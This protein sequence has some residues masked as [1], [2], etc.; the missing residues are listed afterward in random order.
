MVGRPILRS[1]T[2]V[3]NIEIKVSCHEK[4][5]EWVTAFLLLPTNIQPH[6]QFTAAYHLPFYLLYIQYPPYDSTNLIIRFIILT[7]N[8][9]ETLSPPALIQTNVSLMCPSVSFLR[10]NVST[11]D[12]WRHWWSTR[13]HTADIVYIYIRFI[14]YFLYIFTYIQY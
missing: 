7:L 14:M 3:G 5:H 6:L 4:I 12:N 1:N 11:N 9:T 13:I 8:A 10:L 2:K